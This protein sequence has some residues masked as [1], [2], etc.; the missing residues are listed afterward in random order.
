MGDLAR[1]FIVGDEDLA[2]DGYFFVD[3]FD[4]VAC[5][6]VEADGVPSI[7]HFVMQSF[8]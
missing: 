6:Q 1:D 7:S 5:A 8:N 3:A 4:D 2:V